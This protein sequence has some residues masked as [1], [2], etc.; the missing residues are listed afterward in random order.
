MLPIVPIAGVPKPIW[1]RLRLWPVCCGTSAVVSVCIGTDPE[2]WKETVCPT[3]WIDGIDEEQT[4]MH[5]AVYDLRTVP[6]IY[7]LDRNKRVLLKNAAPDEVGSWLSG[8]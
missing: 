7:L 3:G 8:R 1:P 6:A 4:L 2:V 5:D